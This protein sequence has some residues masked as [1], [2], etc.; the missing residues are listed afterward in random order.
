MQKHDLRPQKFF[1][2]LQ[3]GCPLFYFFGLI[4]FASCYRNRQNWKFLEL[5]ITISKQAH[6]CYFADRIE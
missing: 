5:Q 3:R 1:H 4:L 6:P 2:I